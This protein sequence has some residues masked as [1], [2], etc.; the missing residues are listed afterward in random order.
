MTQ[1]ILP[2]LHREGGKFVGLFA[3][4]TLV[5][6]AVRYELGLLGVAMTL[7]CACFFRDPERL[8]PSRKGLIVSPADGVV[9]AVISAAPPKE[10]ELKGTNWTRVSI[11]LNIFN[12]H[13]NRLPLGGKIVKSVY[14][15]GKFLNASLDKASEHNERQSLVVET[16][17]G[18]KI[19]VV[20]I[21][22]LIARRIVCDVSL[23]QTLQTGER[24]GIIRFGSR[25]DV[26]L[27]KGITPLVVE[28]QTMVGG[29]TL[30]A[31]LESQEPPRVGERR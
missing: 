15:P 7:C 8:V 5:L 1:S 22:G 19:A 28:G 16:D 9:S 25:V 13:V 12:V 3:L 23:D 27:P 11:F 2:P 18:L 30:L 6:F 21:A 17:Q 10:L 14:H 29:E 20:Q 4:A 26:Y 24:Y 31:D